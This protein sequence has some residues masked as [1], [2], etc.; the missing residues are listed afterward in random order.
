MAAIVTT[1]MRVYAAKQFISG[2]SDPTQNLYLTIGRTLPWTDVVPN[3]ENNDNA[4]PTPVDS[5]YE[6]SAAFR[7]ML[8]A[9]LISPSDVSLVTPRYNWTSGTIYT[10]YTNN[11]DLFDPSG[12]LPPFFVMTDALNVYKCLNNTYQ[13]VTVASTV[14][15]SGTGTSVISC[16]DGYQWKYMFTVS[17]SDVLRFVTNEWIPVKTLTTND[18][19][20]QWL[21]QQAAVPG[22]IDRIDLVSIGSQYHIPPTVQIV[23]DGVNASAYASH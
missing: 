6:L 16:S 20:A 10:Q 1:N 5:V 8:S 22:T 14:K 17:S 11:M 18:A 9:K 2:F 7:D 23:G 13:G 15:P 21:V 19:S 12:G 4:P 3:V